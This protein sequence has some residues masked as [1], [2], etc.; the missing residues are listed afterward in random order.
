MEV[1]MIRSASK[2]IIFFALLYFASCYYSRP[3]SPYRQNVSSSFY[4]LD[5]RAVL[6][7][8]DGQYL[9]LISSNEYNSNSILNEYGSYGSQYSS[10][11]IFNEY[12]EYGSNYSSKSPFNE[13][14][15]DPPMIYIDNNFIAYLTVNKYKMPRIDPYA[16][17]GYLKSK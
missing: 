17:I 4:L 5:G 13:Y 8:S 3:Y 16:L 1:F 14:A 9:G 6:I 7:S 15:S 12:G 11:S 2:L 10:T